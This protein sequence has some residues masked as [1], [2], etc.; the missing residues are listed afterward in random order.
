MASLASIVTRLRRGS[1]GRSTDMN[2]R[3]GC[4][5]SISGGVIGAFASN[6]FIFHVFHEL[7]LIHIFVDRNLG[8]RK[9]SRSGLE[10]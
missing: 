7:A 1:P 4:R 9:S 2:T 10:N 5:P 8:Q 3:H 6:R